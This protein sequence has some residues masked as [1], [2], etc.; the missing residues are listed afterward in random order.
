MSSKNKTILV[1][2][3]T[4]VECEPIC[5][6]SNET[7]FIAKNVHENQQAVKKP[8]GLLLKSASNVKCTNLPID[9]TSDV[10]QDK[11]NDNIPNAKDSNDFTYDG[12]PIYAVRIIIYDISVKHTSAFHSKC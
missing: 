7:D 1:K 8:S 5:I 9:D 11:I 12:C 4:L 6:D 3:V 10:V 2:R